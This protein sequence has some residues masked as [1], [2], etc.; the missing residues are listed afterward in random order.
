MDIQVKEMARVSLLTITGRVDSNTAQTLGE[1][2]RGQIDK[3]N[4]N[5][6]TDLANVEYMSSAGLREL[7]G[8]LKTVKST[9]GD[10]RI[11]APSDRV[12]EVLDLAGLESVFT[13]FEDVVSAVGSF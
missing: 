8:T 4:K 7:V 2:L 10:L 1:E 13:V 3:G 5:L 6:V 12:R 9:G 11:A